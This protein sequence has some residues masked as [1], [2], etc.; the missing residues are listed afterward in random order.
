M[1]DRLLRLVDR[2]FELYN[3][4]HM[5][6]HGLIINNLHIQHSSIPDKLKKLRKVIKDYYRDRNMII[7]EHQFLEDELREL[8]ACT[9]LSTSKGSLKGRKWLIKKVKNL[10]RLIVTNKTKEFSK[11]N[12]DSFVILGDIFNCLKKEY[13]YKRDILEAVHGKSELAE[14]PTIVRYKTV[15]KPI[16]T[17]NS[18]KAPR[19]ES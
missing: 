18:R 13:E 15:R 10:A 17:P 19:S 4:S 1:Y 6:S 11:V 5:I 9:F 3:P 16:D 2:V 12:H 8:E 7:H 14:I